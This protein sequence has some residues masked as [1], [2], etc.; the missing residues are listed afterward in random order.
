MSRTAS[1]VT[2]SD[3]IQRHSMGNPSAAVVTRDGKTV[4]AEML[5]HL[6]LIERH[7]AFRVVRMIFAVRRLAAVAVPTKICGND[8][9][10]RR[11]LR[12]DHPPGDV[13]LRRAMQQ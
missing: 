12:S 10:F 7:C 3:M 8:G 13:R 6:N 5:H 2:L 9:I 1:F 11:E 4:E